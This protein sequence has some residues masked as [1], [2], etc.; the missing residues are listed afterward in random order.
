MS[1]LIQEIYF[2]LVCFLKEMKIKTKLHKKSI[3]KRKSWLIYSWLLLLMMFVR[4]TVKLDSTSSSCWHF[5]NGFIFG[6]LDSTLFDFFV[7]FVGFSITFY[8]LAMP[9]W[10]SMESKKWNQISFNFVPLR[11]HLIWTKKTL[12]M[13]LSMSKTLSI[14][15]GWM[16]IGGKPV[17]NFPS[18]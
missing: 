7:L 13:T 15:G 14:G 5:S 8:N 17:L 18:V 4:Q 1:I 2:K 3:K 10:L 11:S 9:L 6:Q 12:L 16:W